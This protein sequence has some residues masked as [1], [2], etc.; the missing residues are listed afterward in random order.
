MSI[1]SVKLSPHPQQQQNWETFERVVSEYGICICRLGQIVF[2][3][4]NETSASKSKKFRQFPTLK[5]VTY[6][7]VMYER[8]WFL[9]I[10]AF[11]KFYLNNFVTG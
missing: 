10:P 4:G 6:L 7:Q 8:V 2:V 1:I 9:G 3:S 11:T 5:N